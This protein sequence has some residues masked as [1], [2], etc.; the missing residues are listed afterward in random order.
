MSRLRALVNE[1]ECDIFLTDGT[2]LYCKIYEVKID[3]NRKCT[4]EQHVSRIK[5]TNR[6]EK[7]KINKEYN[8]SKIQSLIT[9]SSNKSPFNYDLCHALL[10]ANIPFHKLQNV[11]FKHFLEKYTNKIISNESTLRKTYVQGYYKE[12]IKKIRNYVENNKMWIS[13]DELTNVQRREVANVVISTLELDRQREHFFINT[14]ILEKVNHSVISKL[15][16]RSLHIIWPHHI[17]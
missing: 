11:A 13:I 4:V 7:I 15:F 2:V 10:S 5:H 1:F 14:A 17:W 12:T 6:I 9:D 8:E 3:E 16:D